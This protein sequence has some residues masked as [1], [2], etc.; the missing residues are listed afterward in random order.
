MNISYLSTLTP[1][2][3]SQ[4]DK[5]ESSKKPLRTLLS[6]SF[7]ALFSYTSKKLLMN[8]LN[9]ILGDPE[10]N[11]QTAVFYTSKTS[12]SSFF[13]PTTS[14]WVSLDYCIVLLL[15]KEHLLI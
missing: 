10:I 13:L 1:S 15:L 8:L 2:S 14:L 4:E 6:F 11:K 3:D 5:D 7:D 9:I 12:V